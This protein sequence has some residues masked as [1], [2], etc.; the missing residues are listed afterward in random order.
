[1]KPPQLKIQYQ[2]EDRPP[3]EAH[4][5][6]VKLH[7]KS[8]VLPRRRLCRG[9]GAAAAFFRSYLLEIGS[10]DWVRTRQ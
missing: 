5:H 8:S 7:L 4:D 1:M 10:L 2:V 3:I 6:L 9:I